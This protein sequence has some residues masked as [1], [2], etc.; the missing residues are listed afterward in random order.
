[1]IKTKKQKV[2]EYSM[3]HSY[4]VVL[5]DIS[6]STT[7]LSQVYMVGVY[8]ILNNDPRL[9]LTCTPENMISVEKKLKE[10]E[11]AGKIT[12]LVFGRRIKVIKDE[13]GRYKEIEDEQK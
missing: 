2:W 13:S 6:I 8:V 7:M 9:Q 5:K 3:S 1:M 12:D 11:T 10:A 4:N